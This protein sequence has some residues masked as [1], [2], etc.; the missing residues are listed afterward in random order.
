M[1]RRTRRRKIRMARPDGRGEARDKEKDKKDEAKNGKPVVVD[2]DGI[3]GR[4]VA[5]PL[6]AGLISD[7][8]A[9]AEGQ[10][11]YIR[12]I[13]TRPGA[14]MEPGQGKPSLRR[15]DLKTREEETLAEGIDGFVLS[16][17]RKKIFYRAG[18]VAGIVDAGKFNKGDGALAL[19]RRDL[20][21]DRAPRR[22][23]P[24]LPRGLADQS[25]LLLCPEHARGR[26]GRGAGEV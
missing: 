19:D 18:E 3:A 7:L 25:R 20:D 15:F 12:R 4:I 1:S 11:Y 26:L 22:V 2:L 5:L 23:G 14:L 24:D 16:A 8:A 17:D 21:P 9:G 10:I 13:T 6:E